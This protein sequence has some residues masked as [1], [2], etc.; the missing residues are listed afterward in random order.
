MLRRAFLLVVCIL[1]P[2]I[3]ATAFLF[4]TRLWLVETHRYINP[5]VLRIAYIVEL[6]LFYVA[7]LVELRSRW[8][9]PN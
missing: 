9:A 2:P 8:S 5:G 7:G 4:A 6:V 1:G 3:L